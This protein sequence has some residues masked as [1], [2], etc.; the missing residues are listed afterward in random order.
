MSSSPRSSPP[1]QAV[2]TLEYENNATTPPTKGQLSWFGSQ[3]AGAEHISGYYYIFPGQSIQ[4]GRDS[5]SKSAH[6][7]ILLARGAH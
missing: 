3:D 2:A 4:F 5:Q 7:N 6:L 1:D